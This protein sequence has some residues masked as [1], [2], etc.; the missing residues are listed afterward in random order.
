LRTR[1]KGKPQTVYATVQ[2]VKPQTFP[3]VDDH[4]TLVLNYSDG[5]AVLEATWDLPPAPRSAR[6]IYGTNGSIVGNEIYKSRSGEP[7]PVSPLPPERAEPIAYMVDRIRH[8]QPLD[9]PS[10]LDLNVAVQE[11]LEAAKISAKTGKVILLPL[12]P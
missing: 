10:A 7:L 6:Q 3:E 12:R 2:H 11:V 1:L 4:A 8:G 9:G 5:F